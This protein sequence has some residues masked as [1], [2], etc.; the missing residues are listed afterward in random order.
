MGGGRRARHGRWAGWRGRGGRGRVGNA[1]MEL[2]ISSTVCVYSIS[3]ADI[4][5]Y[6]Y[7]CAFRLKTT[8]ICLP[9]EDGRQFSCVLFEWLSSLKRPSP[10]TH[11]HADSYSYIYFDCIYYPC[12]TSMRKDLSLSP[13]VRG[14]RGGTWNAENCSR[15]NLRN[16]VKSEERAPSAGQPPGIYGARSERRGGD[17]GD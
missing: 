7:G 4:D 6:P 3:R 1:W 9:L 12:I 15:N 10:H 13:L 2:L 5:L 8:I 16:E 14:A 17:G 11:T